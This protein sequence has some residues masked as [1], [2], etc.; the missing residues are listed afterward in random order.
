RRR[1]G[2]QGDGRQGAQVHAL[3][4]PSQRWARTRVRE[5]LPDRLDPVRRRRRTPGA[6]TG[7]RR[8][9]PVPGDP[10]VPL[11]HERRARGRV[12]HDGAERAERVLPADRPSGGL[13]P[14]TGRAAPLEQHPC[15]PRGGRGRGRGAGRA[16]VPGVRRRRR[17]ASGRE[18]M[19]SGREITASGR[20][21]PLS[22]GR[23]AG[24]PVHS[25]VKPAPWEPYIPVYF[26]LGGISA[27]SWLAATAEDVAGEND[28][29]LIRAGRY[30]SLLTLAGGTVLL[31]A[32][33]GRPERFL[34]MLRIVRPRSAMSLG[35][36]GL[37]LYGG[38]AGAAGAL[39]LLED[40]FP[41]RSERLAAWSRGR[42]GRAIHLA[43]LPLALF[44]GGYTGALLASSSTPAWAA[45]RTVLGPL[46]L[47]SAAST[48]FA[49]VAAALEATGRASPGVRRRLAR[50][51]A[52]ALAGE[53]ALL[54]VDRAKA[55]TL[56]SSAA[57]TRAERLG[58]GLIVAAGIA[59][60]LVMNV[61]RAFAPEPGPPARPRA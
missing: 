47:A 48:G 37:T 26:W 2:Q 30:L 57:A 18:V 16:D 61:A 22:E 54:A 49:A 50:A 32:D 23:A 25:P 15:R 45:R 9:A 59:L 7:A 35:S 14:P 42:L 1:R 10:G 19:V 20:E 52:I 29:A 5:D 46:F 58:R 56:P 3:L 55:T 43:G 24:A 33:L 27:G 39:Q 51:E 28:R 13:Q 44:V 34:N 38:A 8:R 40:G 12:R 6:C 53:A 21:V 41:V 60:P 4:R 17:R 11:R 31:I 36:W